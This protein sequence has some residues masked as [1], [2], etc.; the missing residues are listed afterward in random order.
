[1]LALFAAAGDL[2]TADPALALIGGTLGTVITIL[3]GVQTAQMSGLRHD[4]Q[5]YRK[6]QDEKMRE[7]A[8]RLQQL[9][10]G[11]CESPR[12]VTGSQS[13][14]RNRRVRGKT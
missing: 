7:F 13:S 12:K 5:S 6:D 2:A 14:T 11:A 9:E 1:M 3:T 10:D 8:D 4:F